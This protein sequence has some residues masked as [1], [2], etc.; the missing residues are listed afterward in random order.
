MTTIAQVDIYINFFL[1]PN[2]PAFCR[3]I[4]RSKTGWLLFLGSRAVMEMRE[5]RG[6]RID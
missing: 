5:K 4:F 3:Y 2:T 1:G 6:K